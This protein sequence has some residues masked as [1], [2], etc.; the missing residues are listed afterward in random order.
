MEDN[1][2]N[3]LFEIGLVSYSDSM[4]ISSNNPID[5]LT[6]YM[7]NLDLDDIYD[8]SERVYHTWLDRNFEKAIY[9]IDVLFRLRTARKKY[10]ALLRWYKNRTNKKLRK[11]K[12]SMQSPPGLPKRH[13]SSP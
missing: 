11:R 1:F 10:T 13:K 12:R 3:F 7:T 4:C 5:T 6:N 2:R 9:K 8:L